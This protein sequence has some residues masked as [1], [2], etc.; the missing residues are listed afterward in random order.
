VVVSLEYRGWNKAL[1]VVEDD[2]PEGFRD[3]THAFTLFADSAKKTNPE[4]RG[5]F[6]FG[7]KLVLAIS[8][9]VTIRTTTGGLRFDTDGRHNLRSTQPAGSRV[10][11]LIRMTADECKS[12]EAQ[13][14]KLIPPNGV[15]T[16]F[17]A[18][19]L[20]PR[21]VAGEFRM[22]LRTELAGPDGFLRRAD[23]ETTVRLHDLLPGETASIYEMGIPVV[24]TGD[25]WH[26]DIAQKVPLTIDRE[27]VQPAFLGQVR[28]AVFNRS[29]EH[30]LGDD[31]NS[32]WVEMAVASP[33]CT[34]EAMGS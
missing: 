21:A 16:T 10:E 31:M 13:V 32:E 2:S 29:H 23:R 18:Q 24:E 5:R 8:D 15:V 34:G 28:L 19:Q 9:E 6:N 3:L 26:Y 4:Q 7:E 1:L 14:Q 11:C 22:V 12:V 30:L 20:E 17:N 27:N 33:D 25:K